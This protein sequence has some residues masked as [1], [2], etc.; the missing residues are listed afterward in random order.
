MADL[1]VNLFD[2]D[3]RIVADRKFH[4]RIPI[5]RETPECGCHPVG[6]QIPDID[7]INAVSIK[8]FFEADKEAAN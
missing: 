8:P 4:D 2:T 6:R 5:R 1:G 3:Q 7:Q